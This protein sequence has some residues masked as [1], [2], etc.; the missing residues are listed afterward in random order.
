M[1]HL[2]WTICRPALEATYQI[3]SGQLRISD[4]STAAPCGHGAECELALLKHRSRTE[5]KPGRLLLCKTHNW[6]HRVAVAADRVDPLYGAYLGHKYRFEVGASWKALVSPKEDRAHPSAPY[7]FNERAGIS[8]WNLDKAEHP[9]DAVLKAAVTPHVCTQAECMRSGFLPLSPGVLVCRATSTIHLCSPTQCQWEWRP[10][11]RGKLD[12]ESSK[13]EEESELV[14]WASGKPCS[15]A[16]HN[17]EAALQDGDEEEQM[18]SAA[19]GPKVTMD[20]MAGTEKRLI[21]FRDEAGRMITQIIE[22]RVHPMLLSVPVSVLPMVLLLLLSLVLV[23]PA[24]SVIW[25]FVSNPA[26]VPHS[27]PPIRCRSVQL[28]GLQ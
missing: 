25:P 16:L 2:E 21:K 6:L 17:Q 14:C 24:A 15:A 20:S 13:K 19:S 18:A 1:H 5:G 28:L 9:P 7:W 23:P 26:P 10:P 12:P 27:S 8:V 4:N 3:P 11:K 22:V